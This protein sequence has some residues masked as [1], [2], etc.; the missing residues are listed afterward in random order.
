MIS[1]PILKKKG[2]RKNLI[3]QNAI[4]VWPEGTKDSQKS[5][6]SKTEVQHMFLGHTCVLS[7]G[8]MTLL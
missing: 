7:L 8:Q 2:E 5:S 3:S 1:D 4:S 6:N